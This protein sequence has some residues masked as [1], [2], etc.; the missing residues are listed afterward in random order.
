M[1]KYIAVVTGANKGIGREIAQKLAAIPGIK[2]ILAARNPEAGLAASKSLQDMNLDVEF[3]MLDISSIESINNFVNSLQTDFGRCDILVNNAAIA[4]KNSDP[5]PF[6]QQAAPTILTN[7]F[8]TLNLTQAMLPLLRAA[9][10]TTVSGFPNRIP[11]IVNVASLAGHLRI[12][13]S[14]SRKQ[15]FSS[16]DLT[17]GSLNAAMMEFIADVENG[18]HIEKGWPNTCYGVSK[19]AVIAL[20]KIVARQEPTLMVNSCCPGYCQT[21]MSSH[22]GTKT[23]EEGAR[24]PFLLAHMPDDLSV[25]GKFFSDEHEEEW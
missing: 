3:R 1:S 23:A 5:T 24:T 17:I 13:P 2:V 10:T 22:R 19:L 21:D 14:E 12:L 20:T 15:F 25:T 9:S 11:R 4:F 6:N 18:S 8:G 16:N 7:Y